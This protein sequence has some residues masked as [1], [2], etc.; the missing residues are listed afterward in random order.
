MKEKKKGKRMEVKLGTRV[1]IKAVSLILIPFV[2][3]V[4]ILCIPIDI[5]TPNIFFTN[6]Y[7]STT[8]G[9]IS[10][11]IPIKH[12]IVIIQGRHSFDNY[13]GTFPNADGYP[14]GIRV[15]TNPFNSNSSSFV[16]PFHFDGQKSYKPRDDPSAYHTSYNN[17][18]MNG[19]VYANRND[20]SHGK[21]TISYYDER[22]IPFYWQFASKYVLAERFFGPSM[23]S[24]VVNNLF[25]I[26]A[27]PPLYLQ[28][29]PKGGLDINHT[30]FDELENK[31]IPWKIY[32]EDFRNIMNLSSE[33]KERYLNNIPVL[34][35]PRFTNNLSM[36]SHIEDLK[37]YFNDLRGNNLPSL[38]YIY[39]TQSSDSFSTKVIPAQELVGTLVYALMK[40][41]SWNNSAIII[42]HS[43]SGTYFDHVI[44]PI[45]KN[46][47]KL[48]GFR[49]PAIFISP[50]SKE[51]YIDSSMYDITSVIRFIEYS[52]GILSTTE[53]NNMTNHIGKAFDFTKPPGQPLYLEEITRVI[54]F[55]RANQ[56]QGI[57]TTYALSYI[58]PIVVFLIWRYKRRDIQS[59]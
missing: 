22:D 28:K 25:A 8:E 36:S 23:R 12:I 32:I 55:D 3:L 44:P 21:Y 51:G 27:N 17:G 48:Y 15:P 45:N 57:N 43:E 20:L 5:S 53:M 24:D 39:F 19:F 1:A 47:Q 29:V 16:E 50:Y 11:N 35:I 13:F 41:S 7:A 9:N 14:K 49:V 52:F 40:S 30:I 46:T 4:V 56:V 31:N 2:M 59:V 34:S 54:A 58:V 26:G 10:N 38:S 33:E 18:S 42:T 37:S 6:S